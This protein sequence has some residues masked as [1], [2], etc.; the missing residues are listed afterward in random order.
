LYSGSFNLYLNENG[1]VGSQLLDYYVIIQYLNVTSLNS[2][3]RINGKYIN[4]KYRS[5]LSFTTNTNGKMKI[6]TN[7]NE[8]DEFNYRI[9]VSING[10]KT[11]MSNQDIFSFINRDNIIIFF[12]IGYPTITKTQIN[13]ILGVIGVVLFCANPIMSYILTNK[14]KDKFHFLF[15][16]M[17]IGIISL[18][19]IFTFIYGE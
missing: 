3:A 11:L 1:S 15:I 10:E 5:I 2:T 13:A 9:E 6:L 18:G 7:L 19:L 8:T 16:L 12:E 4:E 14:A 17:G